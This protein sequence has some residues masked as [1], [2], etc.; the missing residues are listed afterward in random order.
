V[1]Y[2]HQQTVVPSQADT[3]TTHAQAVLFAAHAMLEANQMSQA[4]TA[5]SHASMLHCRSCQ[6]SLSRS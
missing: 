4:F 5:G 2:T 6:W 3:I 1:Y